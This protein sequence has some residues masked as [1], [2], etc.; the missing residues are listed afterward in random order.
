MVSFAGG[1]FLQRSLQIALCPP[2]RDRKKGNRH[3][4]L[5]VFEKELRTHG[6]RE[7][8]SVRYLR[9][10]NAAAKSARILANAP[11]N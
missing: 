3:P 5:Y 11:A 6:Q 4:F 10:L 8:E 2:K 7:R 9:A 1:F